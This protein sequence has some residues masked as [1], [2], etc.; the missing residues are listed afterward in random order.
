MSFSIPSACFPEMRRRPTMSAAFRMPTTKIATTIHASVV[1]PRCSSML[2]IASPTSRTIAIA[3]ACERTAR[4]VE[5]IEGALV[6]PQETEQA[7]ERAAIR[8]GAH[9]SE[10]SRRSSRFTCV[11]AFPS[12]ARLAGSFN[13]PLAPEGC[14]SGIT[15][16]SPRV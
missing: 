16:A 15:I 13:Q 14:G 1:V 4:I 3:A 5:T 7:D 8:D 6:R 9:V 10:C 11:S 2:S 12:R